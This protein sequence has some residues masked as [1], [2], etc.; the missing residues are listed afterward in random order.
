[1]TNYIEQYKIMHQEEERY[2]GESLRQHAK[3][4]S[5]LINKYDAKTLLDYGC[6]KGFQYTQ[7]HVHKTFF[8]GIMPSL[9]DPGVPSHDV[10]PEGKFDGVIS[11]DVMEHI[12]EYELD[13]VFKQIYSKADK[14]VYLGICTIP[15]VARLPNG[16]N[17]HCT[18]KPIEWW[19]EKITPH[20]NKYTV[21]HCY[22]NKRI[23]QI[24]EG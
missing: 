20:A 12:P 14:F 13:E 11:T 4:I 1:M 16:E 15:A 6:G 19:V 9:Y 7:E 2:P 3:S 18:V 23:T 21:V 24:I 17:A 8:N 5:D 22:G 10:I